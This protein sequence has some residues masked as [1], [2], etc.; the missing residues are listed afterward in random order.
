MARDDGPATRERPVVACRIRLQQLPW[1]VFVM[2]AQ[3]CA[4]C[5]APRRR[6][7]YRHRILGCTHCRRCS[8]L[9]RSD[10]VAT[11]KGP[12]VEPLA[13]MTHSPLKRSTDVGSPGAVWRYEV[14][15]RQ[16]W[17]DVLPLT[18]AQLQMAARKPAFMRSEG[19][20]KS[21]N[22]E[23]GFGFI[24]LTQGGR[25]MAPTSFGALRVTPQGAGCL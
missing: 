5:L 20:L 24:E 21:W 14:Y 13:S 15:F 18:P 16:S 19:T 25:D 10:V 1:T 23:R 11:S 17:L 8:R 2:P 6:T 12:S 7:Q 3:S 4:W 9:N 22:A